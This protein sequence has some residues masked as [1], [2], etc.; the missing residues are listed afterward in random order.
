MLI[1]RV[2]M[3]L[4]LMMVLNNLITIVD[5]YSRATWTHLS[6]HKSNA[7]SILKSFISFFQTQF[8]TIVKILRSD[9][10]TEF[11]NQSTLSFYA[12]NGIIHQTSCKATPQQNGIVERKHK[13]LLETSRALF[14]QSQIL[15]DFGVI[16]F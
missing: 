9:N 8:H 4:Q 5:D 16:V 12:F 6:S 13:H 14:F 2:L 7:F 1:F 10:G 11:S 15:S 3:I